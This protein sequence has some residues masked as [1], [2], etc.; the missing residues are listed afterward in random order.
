MNGSPAICSE[1]R[2]QRWHNT[3][4]SRSSSTLDE[5]AM[6]LGK[7]RL[8]SRKRE[9]ARPLLIAWFCSGHSPPLSQIG[10]S[11][12]WLM[13][14]SS[15]TPCCALSAITEVSWVCTTMPGI[16]VVVHDAGG[17][18]MARPLP[19]SVTSTRHCRQ[20]PAGSSSGWSQK[21]GIAMPS[22]SAARI[23]S[24]PLGTEISMPSIVTV[25]RSSF[26]CTAVMRGLPA[27]GRAHRGT[28]TRR[29]RRAR[30]TR[31]GST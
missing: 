19:M 9:S 1:K 28:G 30:G 22:C 14:S 4:R 21:R 31:R 15:I 29:L 8:T 20:A 2:V 26:P 16:T 18:G 5:I 24:V 12:G 10:Q 11:S 25:T 7:V 27:P 6:G 23:S 17:L 3:Q 13:S